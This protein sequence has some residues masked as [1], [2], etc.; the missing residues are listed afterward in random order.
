MPNSFIGYNDEAYGAKPKRLLKNRK[1]EALIIN[2]DGYPA[3]Y[4]CEAQTD[5]DA[6]KEVKR[7]VEKIETAD[8]PYNEQ[9]RNYFVS[10]I[11]KNGNVTTIFK[12][13]KNCDTTDTA[14]WFKDNGLL[15]D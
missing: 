4:W 5:D 11:H 8:A 3:D 6:I 10:K 12:D 14:K 15:S 13:F 9:I 2:A 1:Y 7:L